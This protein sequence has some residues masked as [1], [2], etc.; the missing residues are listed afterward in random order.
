MKLGNLSLG[1]LL[2]F[3]HG[4]RL[5]GGADVNQKVRYLLLLSNGWLGCA[6]IKVLIY[7]PR[8][9]TQDHRA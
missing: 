9:G 7:L 2:V 1:L 8:I 3:R 6:N 4:E 5:R